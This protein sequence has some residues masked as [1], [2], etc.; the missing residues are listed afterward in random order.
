[1][2]PLVQQIA[3]VALEPG[4]KHFILEVSLAAL[5]LHRVD[6]YAFLVAVERRIMR[7]DRS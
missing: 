5:P 2:I 3:A 7:S 1:V 4:E 6:A